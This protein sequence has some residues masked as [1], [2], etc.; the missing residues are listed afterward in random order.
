MNQTN[1]PTSP[2]PTVLETIRGAVDQATA[3]RV[4][5]TPINQ[6]G[7]IVLPVARIAGAGGGGGGSG[8]GEGAGQSQGTG[9]GLRLSAKPLGVFVIKD[10][11]VAWRPAI[12]VGRAILGGQVVAI[13]A[14]LTVR[15]LIRARAR[16][17]G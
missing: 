8:P 11:T 1:Q 12:D 17:P 15:A 2:G 3:G 5:G 9:G 6:D 7:V 13:V 10:G 14:L 16:R 4:F